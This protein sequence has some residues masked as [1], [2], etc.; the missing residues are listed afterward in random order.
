MRI[1]LALSLCLVSGLE[2]SSAEATSADVG[3]ANNQ[4]DEANLWNAGLLFDKFDL[5]LAPGHRTEAAGP[6]YYSE[7]KETQHTWALPPLFSW[8]RDP[9]TDWE[10][11][12]LA[13]PLLT[14]DRF[15][16]QYRWQLF[17][18]LSFSGGATQQEKERDR[19]TI[20]PFYFQQRS[21]NPAE[22]YTALF[23]IYGRLKNRI[24]RD[25]IFFVMFPIY[26]QTRRREVVTDN[27][28]YPFFHVRQGPG[29]RGWQFLPFYGA[30]HKDVTTRTNGFKEVET[31][32]GHDRKFVLWPFFLQQTNGVGTDNPSRVQASLPAYSLE[33]SPR[34]DVSTVLWPF[35]S[36]IDEREK[37]YREWQTP[38]PLIIHA[39]GEGKTTTRVFPF[40]SRAKT[41]T[42]E[43][44]FY[45]WPVYKYNRF[46][47]DPL[48]RERTRIFFFLYSDTIARNTQTGA[49]DRRIDFWP[50]FTHRHDLNGNTR[51]QVFSVLEPLIPNN[52][53]I[54]RDYSH[55]W[56]VWRAENNVKTGA[57]SQSLLWNLYRREADA[58]SR[59]CS[60]LFGLFQY[61][62]GAGG[63][64]LR[65]FYIPMGKAE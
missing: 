36:R 26:G 64:Q 38:W 16:E 15:G 22:N 42:L 40:F 35:F 54:E 34:R 57:T 50:L 61:Q 23:P 28:L 52:K 45:M 59:K 60:L 44:Q 65:L 47:S 30:E 39:R 1:I 62:S 13:Y 4:S 37:K 49:Y 63:K 25:E 46:H 8:A 27:Y 9:V 48:D 53:S 19:F 18:L 33:R 58:D 12:D 56:S 5:T 3:A 41:A 20:F 21:S 7:Q 32:G 55:V 10:E 43:S 24:F 2:S 31:I 51:L 11:I 6:F 29:L 14:Y 17:Q